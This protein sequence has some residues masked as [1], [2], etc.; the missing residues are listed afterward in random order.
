VNSLF[1]DSG[2][3]QLSDTEAWLLNAMVAMFLLVTLLLYTL[4]G[5]ILWLIVFRE[6]LKKRQLTIA[7]M[8]ALTA[9]LAAGLAFFLITFGW[10]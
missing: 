7:S 5:L 6:T 9:V 2:L 10:L 4:P 8:L 1:A 3:S